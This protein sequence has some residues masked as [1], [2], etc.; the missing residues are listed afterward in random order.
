MEID[1]A[2]LRDWAK[3]G[4]GPL[5]RAQT[6][7]RG[8]TT[9]SE[10]NSLECYPAVLASGEWV[11]PLIDSRRHQFDVSRRRSLG[12]FA[13]LLKEQRLRTF[14][15]IVDHNVVVQHPPCVWK[16]EPNRL[17]V[18]HAPLLSIAE[19]LGYSSFYYGTLI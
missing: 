2:S 4:A 16:L 11:E 8:M 14:G 12:H 13:G 18:S 6:I 15:C 3:V 10:T 5:P 1:F 19:W 7:L 9:A 17:T